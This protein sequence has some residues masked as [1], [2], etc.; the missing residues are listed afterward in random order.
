MIDESD[1]GVGVQVLYVPSHVR[2][3]Y[4]SGLIEDYLKSPDTEIGFISSWRDGTVFCRFYW[5][6]TPALRT[7]ANSEGCSPEDL[8]AYNYFPQDVH[9]LWGEIET[10]DKRIAEL[11]EQL[12][13]AVQYEVLAKVR[14]GEGSWTPLKK[15]SNEN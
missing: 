3:Q 15:E 7:T 11:V 2:E 9:E 12:K 1:L 10:R 13:E 6:R 4:K 14:A 5:K 8:I